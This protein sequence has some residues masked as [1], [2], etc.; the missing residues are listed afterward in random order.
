VTKT[1]SVVTPTLT[2]A[3]SFSPEAPKAGQAVQFTNTST[4]A[5]NFAW[6]S[7]PAGFSATTEN[8]SYAFADAGTY[9]VTLTVQDVFGN[10]ASV[11]QNVTV[12]ESTS[13]GGDVCEEPNLCNLPACYVTQVTTT[14]SGVTN[15]ST[16]EYTTVAGKK[17]I[18]KLTNSGAGVTVI[19]E[20][21]YDGQARNT[22]INSR[23]QTAFGTTEIYTLKEWNDC[24]LVKES[25][26]DANNTLTGYSTYEYDAQG[27]VTRINSY[28]A[29]DN[30]T[31]YS[32]DED[33][34]AQGLP[35]KKSSFNADGS[36]VS[37]TT[38]TYENC[39]PKT[40]VGKDASGATVLNQVNTFN[41]N[42]FISQ[43]TTET[44][45]SQSGFT[46]TTTAVANYEY[47]CE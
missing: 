12:S 22:R 40:L 45:V 4:G 19:S 13:G 46:F 37:E 8:P 11:T 27:R 28:D 35:Q 20:Y 23:T 10:Q 41:A 14:V 7:E 31:G 38:L 36:L 6:S 9:A 47:A 18:S 43:S 42:G 16:F 32:R 17:V 33:F 3:F 39:Q 2:A 44:T 34:N 5:I 1:V 26:Y 30:L 15:T 24:Q 29:S 21:E 25:S